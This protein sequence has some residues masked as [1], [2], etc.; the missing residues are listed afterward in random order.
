MLRI[1]CKYNILRRTSH[2]RQ[3][4]ALL[5]LVAA[6]RHAL[7]FYVDVWTPVDKM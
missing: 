5:W 7:Y 2:R 6:Q 3:E 1:I 4:L